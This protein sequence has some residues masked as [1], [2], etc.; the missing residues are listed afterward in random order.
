MMRILR[1]DRSIAYRSATAGSVM[2]SILAAVTQDAVSLQTGLMAL[3]LV[4]I[5]F[6]YSYHRR[7]YRNVGLKVILAIGLFVAFGAF[8]S[9][10]R[11]AS[12]V[13]DTRAPLVAVFLWVQVLH[14]FDVPRGRDLSFSVAASVVLVALAGSLAFSS[15]FLLYVVLHAVFFIASLVL[16]YDHELHNVDGELARDVTATRRHVTVPYGTLV[17][18]GTAVIVVTIV[19]TAFVFIFL[20]RLPAQ[21]VASLPF[22]FP[23][24]SEIPG[25]SGGVSSPGADSDDRSS[26]EAFDPENYFGYGD[27]LNLRVR[28]RLAD[29]LV[30]RVRAPS[31]SLYRGQSYDRYVDGRWT[32]SDAELS[33][34]RPSGD[35]IFI[36]PLP[37]ER[38]MRARE[39]LIQTF[40][41]ERDLPN[42]VFHAQRAHQLFVSETRVRVDD[43]GSVRLPFIV[44]KHTIYSVI[45]EVPETD[46]AM[47][48]EAFV[49]NIDDPGLAPFLQLPDTLHGRFT[50]L[51]RGITA[52]Q[53]TAVDKALA[54]QAWIRENKSYLLEISPDPPRVD[55]V[56]FFVFERDEGFC[57]QIAATMALM[58]RAAG[59]PTRIVTGF[60]PGNRNIFT[61]YWEV[62]NKDAHAWVEVL[63]PGFGWVPYDP[64]FGVPDASG[65]NTTFMLAPLKKIA[66]FFSSGAMGDIRAFFGRVIDAIPGPRWIGVITLLALLLATAEAVRRNLPRRHGTRDR[67]DPVVDAWLSLEQALADQGWA[68]RPHETPLEFVDRVPGLVAD[69]KE[70]RSI[71]AG[72]NEFRYARDGAAREGFDDWEHRARETV[73][74]VRRAR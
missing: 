54:V 45:S 48:R 11:F 42:I 35:S 68:R 64:T 46:P 4:P 50:E 58:L 62:N 20:P 56:D 63:Y 52:D 18:R 3:V 74:A 41:V 2:V 44:E 71:A 53:P 15:G 73:D 70:L 61:G 7:G 5:G 37:G 21:Q 33:E 22:D 24:S 28:G 26:S 47:L 51:A 29:E 49:P 55:P 43:F 72:F 16:A 38:A 12:S 9:A 23:R 34:L 65:A 57:E 39:E 59:V 40:Y 31:P 1:S 69:R 32:S 25:F 67:P 17:R 13:D 66:E 60:G 10:V 6:V 14:S 8:L 30:M 27:S 19:A 36:P